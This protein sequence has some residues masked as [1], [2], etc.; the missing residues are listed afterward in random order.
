M[1]ER[2]Q[3]IVVCTGNICRSPMGERLLAH[4]LAAEPPPLCDLEVISAGVAALPGDPASTNS[5]RALEKVGLDLRNHRSRPFHPRLFDR[6]LLILTMTEGHRA[7]LVGQ[8]QDDSVPIF[9]FREL[10]EG[11]DDPSVPDPFGAN[12][13]EYLETR[14]ALAEAVPSIVQWLREN[15]RQPA[16]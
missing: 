4:A 12:L 9:L 1:P 6:A 13:G 11:L 8:Y 2:N 7:Q 15:H 10:M 14:D 16:D 3:V 5:V